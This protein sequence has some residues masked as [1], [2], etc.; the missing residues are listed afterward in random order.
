[1]P[2]YTYHNVICGM[3]DNNIRFSDLRKLML[4]LGFD[5]RIKG[6]HFIYKKNG[7]PERIV[8][9]PYGNKAKAYQV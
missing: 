1:M 5:E 7:I 8:I 2:N 6:D 4:D 3:R 9:Q